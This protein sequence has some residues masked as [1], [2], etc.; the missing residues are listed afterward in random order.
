MTELDA[1]GATLTRV[2]NPDSLSGALIYLV[3]S[4]VFAVA[5]NRALRTF[6]RL[7]LKR[8]VRGRIDRTAL[9]FLQQLGG[10]FIWVFALVLYAHLIPPLRTLGTALL[11]GVS[12]VS[13]VIGLAAQNTLGN[14]VAG[15]ALL[16]YRPFEVGDKVQVTAPTGLETGTVESISLGYTILATSD[17]RRVVL[18]NS[19][20]ANQ[21]TVNLTDA[22]PQVTAEVPISVA[23]E[24]DIDRARATIL[25]LARAHPTVRFPVRAPVDPRTRSDINAGVDCPVVALSDKGVDFLLRAPCANADAAFT[26]RALLLEGVKKRFDE[27]GIEMPH[28]YTKVT[29]EDKRAAQALAT[30][31]RAE[32]SVKT[33]EA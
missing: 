23:Y 9:G 32:A 26:F 8:D 7:S 1:W 29:L 27:E 19:T 17:H 20:I 21:T 14:L 15:L 24:A 10:I 5:A 31:G 18:S 13:V 16:I 30:E 6:V 3:L 25:K 2:I 28:T 33:Y 22:D 4:I 11:A 12:V